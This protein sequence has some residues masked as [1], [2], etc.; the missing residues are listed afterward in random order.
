[1]RTQRK[2]GQVVIIV[3]VLIPAVLL[4]LA[5]AVD[6]GRLFIER[7]RMAR[8]AQSAANAGIS[9][10]AERMVTQAAARQTELAATPSPTP[11]G[12]MTATPD[13]GDVAAWLT[14]DD[15]AALTSGA[16]PATAEA[17]ARDYARRNGYDLADADTLA[18]EVTYPQPGY[19]PA[20][21]TMPVLRML[22]SIQR[23]TEVLLAGLLG[24]RFADL[25]AEARSEIRQR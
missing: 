3:A 9:V 1:M 5:V 13:P 24:D 23:R 19:D 17:A 4:F 18:V 14:A 11:P 6:A 8:A 7:G 25:T 20:D 22:V 2:R 16:F 15:R 10:V 12:T 21:P